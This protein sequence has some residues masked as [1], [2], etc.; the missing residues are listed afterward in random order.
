MTKR[1]ML[2]MAA[3]A[4]DDSDAPCGAAL[5]VTLTGMAAAVQRTDGTR[6][7]LTRLDA[8]LLAVLALEGSASRQR[9]LQL[10]WPDQE[11]EAA[12]NALRQRLFRL[13]RAMG[14]ELVSGQEQL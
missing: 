9:L 11:P 1:A 5:H 7:P 2:A 8:A 14:A 13:R 4:H 12:R 6:V 10:L 3:A